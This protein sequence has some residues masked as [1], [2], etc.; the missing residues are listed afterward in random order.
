VAGGVESLPPDARRRLEQ[1]A[2]A[3]ER[4][5]VEELTLYAVGHPEDGSPPATEAA[6][7]ALERGLTSAIED[8]RTAVRAYVERSH[9]SAHYRG[10][11]SLNVAPSLGPTADWVRVM[12]SL[13][14]AV[15]ALVLDDSL[16]E[17]DR[18]EL[19]GAWAN[20]LP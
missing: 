11:G 10:A 17:D 19:L 15:I 8:A 1:F 5:P 16:R 20:L 7:V 12:R 4:V 14:D 2:G 13:D 6:S 3:L 18:A 9:A